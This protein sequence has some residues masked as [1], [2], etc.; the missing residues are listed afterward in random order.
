MSIYCQSNTVISC[1][2]SIIQGSNNVIKG[3]GN[4]IR[5]SGN[6]VKGNRNIVQGS[7]N[8]VEGSYNSI[9]GSN[10]SSRGNHNTL[11]GSNNVSKGDYDTSNSVVTF[12]NN[13]SVSQFM[14]RRSDPRLMGW[15]PNMTSIFSAANNIVSELYGDGGAN[16]QRSSHFNSTSSGNISSTVEKV[17]KKI[18]LI[19]PG[20]DEKSKAL[21]DGPKDSCSICLDNKK[22][23]F[24]DCCTNVSLCL[25]CTKKLCDGKD[26]GQVKCPM[27]NLTFTKAQRVYI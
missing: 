27:C 10:N 17:N 16:E 24:L 19:L 9:D 25:G 6:V 23:V 22:C 11:Q 5:G 15:Q 14:D 4:T 18:N 7:G 21:E 26:V 8:D 20:Q 3:D 1:S 13:F 2:N 12:G